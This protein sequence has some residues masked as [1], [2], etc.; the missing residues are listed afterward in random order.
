MSV[1]LTAIPPSDFSNATGSPS[2]LHALNRREHEADERKT[3][4]DTTPSD[5]A[6]SGNGIAAF[7]HRS[8]EDFWCSSR[9]PPSSWR[10]GC[11]SFSPGRGGKYKRKSSFNHSKSYCSVY[12]LFVANQKSKYNARIIADLNRNIKYLTDVLEPISKMD[13]SEISPDLDKDIQALL[14]YAFLTTSSDLM[15]MLFIG[16]FLSSPPTGRRG[17]LAAHSIA[18]LI[19]AKVKMKYMHLLRASSVLWTVI[20]FVW[21]QIFED[22]PN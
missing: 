16:N 19:K 15:P 12:M 21:N 4:E 11:C 1:F 18:L 22:H 9:R 20:K 14:K 7:I 5:A 13:K 17:S 8:S 6:Y 2:S 3:Q 10:G